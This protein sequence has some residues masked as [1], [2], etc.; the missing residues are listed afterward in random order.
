MHFLRF[1]RDFKVYLRFLWSFTPV[2][3][4]AQVFIRAGKMPIHVNETIASIM[5]ELLTEEQ[6]RYKIIK[7]INRNFTH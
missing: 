2:T 5:K 7:K 4:V 6:A 3:V 1:F